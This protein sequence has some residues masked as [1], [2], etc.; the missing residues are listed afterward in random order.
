MN[1]L[2]AAEHGGS[3][4]LEEVHAVTLDLIGDRT[5]AA[6]H[7]IAAL[8]QQQPGNIINPRADSHGRVD[9]DAELQHQLNAV[10]DPA[11]LSSIP[12][13]GPVLAHVLELPREA[14]NP[15]ADSA[16]L[17]ESEEAVASEAVRQIEERREQ[18][19]V[20]LSNWFDETEWPAL[21]SSRRTHDP[22]ES[23]M[24][25]AQPVITSMTREKNR[26]QAEVEKLRGDRV[27][28]A[29]TFQAKNTE[30]S[31]K[32]GSTLVSG[33]L[34]HQQPGSSHEITPNQTSLDS[35]QSR[36]KELTRKLRE[37][38]QK[39]KQLVGTSAGSY[40]VA[41]IL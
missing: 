2:E 8:E 25:V 38:E 1:Q 33:S 14:M 35:L 19:I 24:P 17:G 18:A 9:D 22:A 31:T 12:E 37:A 11:A 21:N 32:D 10:H 6:D 7:E 39:A 36:V 13:D 5:T 41:V 40:C 29:A 26:L 15:A 28:N 34:V 23:K 16:Q 3:A 27:S 30:T 20:E 4:Y